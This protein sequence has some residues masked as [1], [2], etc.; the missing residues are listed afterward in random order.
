MN[1]CPSGVDILAAFLLRGSLFQPTW[2]ATSHHVLF[3]SPN[4]EAQFSQWKHAGHLFCFQQQRCSL[5]ADVALS[6][7]SPA[8]RSNNSPAARSNNS[9]AARSLN[10]QAALSNNEHAACSMLKRLAQTI[11]TRLAQTMQPHVANS[12]P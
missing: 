12:K 9:P 1:L 8:A 2:N 4:I 5:N 11:N 6:N 3:S 10:A 7:N